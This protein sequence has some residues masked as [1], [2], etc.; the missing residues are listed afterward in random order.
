MSKS[1]A[2]LCSSNVAQLAVMFGMLSFWKAACISLKK[3]LNLGCTWLDKM[4][5]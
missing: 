3:Y 1:D 2:I 5:A 4:P